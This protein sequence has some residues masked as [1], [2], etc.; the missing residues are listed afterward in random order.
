MR[1]DELLP[2]R[3][4]GIKKRKR[5]HQLPNENEEGGCAKGG[6]RRNEGEPRRVVFIPKRRSHAVRKTRGNPFPL[7]TSKGVK[8]W[9]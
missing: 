3:R 9:T 8:T 7:E 4:H 5:Y 2:S 1:L 6:L